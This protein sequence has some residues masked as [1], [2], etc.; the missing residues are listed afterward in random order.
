M[1]ENTNKVIQLQD[2]EG[3][4]VSPVVNVGS[5]YDKNGQKIDNLLSY[6]VAGTDVP[7]PDV[8]D[9]TEGFQQYA[10]TALQDF[11]DNPG[12]P[13][14]DVREYEIGSGVTVS[15]GDVVDIKRNVISGSTYENLSVGSII[16]VNENGSPV[17]YI[18]VHQG[19][20]NP[21]L[22]DA[23]CDGTWIL[24]QDIAENRI[25][26]DTSVQ[27][28]LPSGGYSNRYSLSSMNTY[29]NGDWMGRY[30]STFLSSVKTVKIP[31]SEGDTVGGGSSTSKPVVV[32]TLSDGLLCRA[33]LLSVCE[34]GYVGYGDAAVP[35]DGTTLQYFQSADGQ[36]TS[37]IRIANYNG[38]AAYW[39]ART[40]PSSTH[41]GAYRVFTTGGCGYSN[42][43]NSEQYGVR[44]CL[45][46]NKT[47]PI[48]GSTIVYSKELVTKESGS[49]SMGIAL[50]S[51]VSGDTVHVCFGGYCECSAA[52]T[53]QVI[54]GSGEDPVKAQSPKDGWLWV[55][56][57]H[58]YYSITGGTVY[59][60]FAEASWDEIAEVSESGLASE[61]YSLGD[62]KDIEISGVGTMT[63]EIAD[64]NHDYLSGSTSAG[65][66]GISMIT[67]DLL[68]STRQMNSSDTNVGGFPASDL[69]DYLNGDIYNGLPADL[70]PHVKTIYKWYCTGNATNDGEWNGCK[71]WVPLEYEFH[72]KHTYGPDTEENNGN[73]RKYPIFTDD[74]SRAKK[75]NNGSGADSQ[76][77]TATPSETH[78]V[79]FV[80]VTSGGS[81]NGLGLSSEP[82][83]VCFG[84]SI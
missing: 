21:S 24:R 41:I 19:N 33:F 20:P 4:D 14:N 74:A 73:A 38:S 81:Y 45:I 7:I 72:G 6:V 63:L 23:S 22:Y 12:L 60:P 76:Y 29:L 16:Q 46:L 54:T 61:I 77:W 64:F 32:N 30:E 70:K 27:V 58:R 68:P 36:Q 50:D 37:A 34:L 17:N 31:Y 26:S 75:L 42:S 25:W 5:I 69:Y 66:A 80:R 13:V 48:P 11:I 1:P 15:V 44:P 84:L 55:N 51:G 9:I 8:G 2:N 52:T 71:I 57:I 67:R 62:T 82:V 35:S 65:M 3:N 83:G 78:A 47:D 43:I 56:P 40:T 10:D 53:G 79:N 59:S 18:V 28:T 39:W 49:P